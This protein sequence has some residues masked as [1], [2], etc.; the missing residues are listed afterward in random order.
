MKE[1]KR[2]GLIRKI[3]GAASEAIGDSLYFRPY[4]DDE[5]AIDEIVR[6]TGEKRSRVAQ[7][8]IRAAIAGR[9]FEVESDRKIPERIEWLIRREKDRIVREDAQNARLERIEEAL[10]IFEKTTAETYCLANV[11]VSYLNQLFTALKS[12]RNGIENAPPERKRADQNA[13]LLI[14]HALSELARLAEHHGHASIDP[15]TLFLATK[16]DKLRRR[17][18]DGAETS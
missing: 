12:E 10:R 5:R 4:L 1:R 2:N 15:E 16:I 11:A 6:A 14:E 7:M 13:L 3:S 9:R 17:I 8:L 18:A